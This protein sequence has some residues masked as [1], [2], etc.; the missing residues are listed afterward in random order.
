MDLIPM[1]V[2]EIG[3]TLS[4]TVFFLTLT[5]SKLIKLFRNK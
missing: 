3:L 4:Q 1:D 5:A 2:L